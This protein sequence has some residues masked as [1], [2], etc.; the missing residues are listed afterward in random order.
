MS[1]TKKKYGQEGELA[2]GTLK[3]NGPG[4]KNSCVSK[5]QEEHASGEIR[6]VSGNRKQNLKGF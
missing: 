2:P 3:K 4:Q 1:V 5:A 6:R